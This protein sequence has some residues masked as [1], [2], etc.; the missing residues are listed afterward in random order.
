MN[1]LST[2]DQSLNESDGLL[3]ETMCALSDDTRQFLRHSR[4][5]MESEN[6]KKLRNS[7]PSLDE[8][9]WD[10]PRFQRKPPVKKSQPVKKTLR[11]IAVEQKLGKGHDPVLTHASSAPSLFDPLAG[12]MDGKSSSDINRNCNTTSNG[13][14]LQQVGFEGSKTDDSDPFLAI[15]QRHRSQQGGTTA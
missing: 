2:S 15:S 8:K 13:G 4:I 7:N 11:E 12:N 3:C 10:S 9:A 14:I 1:G 6:K 5:M